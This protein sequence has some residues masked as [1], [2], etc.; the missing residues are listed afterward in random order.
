MTTSNNESYNLNM[1]HFYSAS[2]LLA[3]QSAVLATG[4]LSVCLFIYT[5]H[6]GIVSRWMKI[7]SFSFR[8]LVGQSI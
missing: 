7:R 5:S 2:A 3:M 6:A 8:H 1:F 4:I